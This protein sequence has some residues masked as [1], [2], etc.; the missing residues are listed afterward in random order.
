MKGAAATIFFAAA[1]FLWLG[2]CAPEADVP[3]PPEGPVPDVVG[4]PF[5]E[6]CRILQES[7]YFAR[8][9]PRAAAEGREPVRV[10]AQEPAAGEETGR[11]GIVEVT[12]SG[13]PSEQAF[14]PEGP[15]A[16]YNEVTLTEPS[17]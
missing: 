9:E 15:C 4:Q 13:S 6:A 3:E 5:A 17:R 14:S 8:P 10:T 12:L 11:L 16:I 7:G 1:A 2:A